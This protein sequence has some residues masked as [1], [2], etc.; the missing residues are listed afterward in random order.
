[1]LCGRVYPVTEWP[2]PGVS[3][4]FGK[5]TPV[6]SFDS[7]YVAGRKNGADL[8]PC[9]DRLIEGDEI[10]VFSADQVCAVRVLSNM[11]HY[12]HHLA[13][14]RYFRVILCTLSTIAR[15]ERFLHRRC[16]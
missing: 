1:M 10:C 13:A 12:S 11:M 14:I 3:P 6:A 4:L 2:K 9:P 15:P 8:Y 5:P 7:H 16:R